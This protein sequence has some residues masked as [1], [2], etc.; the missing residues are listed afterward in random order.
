M[1][2]PKLPA[3]LLGGI[4]R[5]VRRNAATSPVSRALAKVL[6]P[7]TAEHCRVASQRGGRLLVDVDSAPLRAELQSFRREEIRLALNEHLSDRKF[8][9]IH[10]RLHTTSHG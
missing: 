2:D 4:L 7:A 9:A 6:G 10:F 3:D 8:S 1:A 5:D